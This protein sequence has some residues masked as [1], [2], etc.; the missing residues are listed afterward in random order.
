MGALVWL[1]D[2]Y[3]GPVAHY[4]VELRDGAALPIRWA[5]AGRPLG[6][7]RWGGPNAASVGGNAAPYC[8]PSNGRPNAARCRAHGDSV[9]RWRNAGNT[10]GDS[11][12]AD[13]LAIHRQHGRHLAY[14]H[15]LGDVR[16][17]RHPNPMSMAGRGGRRYDH[18]LPSDR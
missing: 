1:A 2:N 3:A 12:L 17:L 8:G 13:H 16:I 10:P 7:F 14:H 5:A 9:A 11:G 15:V 6:G 18:I 4:S